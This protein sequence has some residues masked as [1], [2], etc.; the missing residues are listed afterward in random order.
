MILFDQNKEK[1]RKASRRRR[2]Q[3]LGSG[4]QVQGWGK[5]DDKG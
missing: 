3:V 5:S 4:F 1:R 2:K